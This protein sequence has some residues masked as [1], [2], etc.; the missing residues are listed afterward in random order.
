MPWW[1]L[2]GLVVVVA[3]LPLVHVVVGN[4]HDRSSS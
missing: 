1:G 3:V 4:R 2:W